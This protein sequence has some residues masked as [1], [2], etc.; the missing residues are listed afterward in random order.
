MIFRQLQIGVFLKSVVGSY[1]AKII[2][3]C[4]WGE[5]KR[6]GGGNLQH[7][8]H[9]FFIPSLHFH[10]IQLPFLCSALNIISSITLF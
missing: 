9:F 4:V 5:R 3:V 2:C 10:A 8:L 1:F 6:K 7:K